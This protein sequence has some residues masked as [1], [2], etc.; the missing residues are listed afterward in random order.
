MVRSERS[1]E[2]LVVS[3]QGHRVLLHVLGRHVE[4]G[5]R[6]DAQPLPLTQGIARGSPMSPQDLPVP[7]DEIPGNEMLPGV[8]L[9][10]RAVV[11]FGDEADVLAVTL[12]RVDKAVGLRDFP[13]LRLGQIPQRKQGVGQ[14]LLRQKVEHVSLVL[15]GIRRLPEPRSVGCLRNTGIMARGQI[16]TAQLRSAPPQCPE[17]QM[18]VAG[19]TGIGRSARFI[20]RG[21]IRHHIPVKFPGK[22][23]RVMGDPQR[24]ADSLGIL[25][26]LQGAAA[27]LFRSVVQPHGHADAVISLL[28]QPQRRHGG[29]HSAA[30][31]D[32]TFG[33][34][35][36]PLC[37]ISLSHRR[38]A[39]STAASAKKSPPRRRQA[40]MRF[41]CCGHPSQFPGRSSGRRSGSRSAGLPPA[42]SAG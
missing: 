6:R 37:F 20:L 21:K 39:L 36:P 25:H 28:Q 29:V 17:L 31:S 22:V 9:Q 1:G 16:V 12:F 4:P 15:G 5:L 2:Q 38:H 18:H 33:H 7:V 40:L 32:H 30:H 34:L 8:F 19:N 26:I 13:D 23:E 10:E 42:G 11:S 41:V 14:L 24:A 27:P 3:A 35:L